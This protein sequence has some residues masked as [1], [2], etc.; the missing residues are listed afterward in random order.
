MKARYGNI[1]AALKMQYVVC[2]GE[3]LF[4]KS[5]M[6][7]STAQHTKV[8]KLNTITQPTSVSTE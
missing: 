5:N 2:Y 7:Q 4:A 3:K 8:R 1:K 6:N